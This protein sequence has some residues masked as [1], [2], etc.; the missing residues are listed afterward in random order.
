VSIRFPGARLQWRAEGEMMASVH[1]P[2]SGMK[3]FTGA[4]ALRAQEAYPGVDIVV[5]LQD[6]RLKSEFQLRAGV[7]PRLP[8]Y[9]LDGAAVRAGARGES[10]EVDAGDGWSWSEEGLKTWQEGPGGRR[11]ERSARFRIDGQCVSFAISGVDDTMPLTIDPELVFSSYL[12]GGMF[13][14]ITAVA[15]DSQGNLYLGGWTE[16]SDFLSL[17]GYQNTA[18]GRID[19]FVAKVNAAGQLVFSSYL[20]GAGEDRVQAIAVDGAGVITVAGLTSSTNFPTLSAARGTLAGGRDA[21]VTR[22]YPAGNQLVFSTYLGGSGHDAALGMAL[23]FSGN[24]VV[25]GET[26]S[27]DFPVQNA[28]ASSA[29]GGLDGFLARL[30]PAGALLSSSYFGGGADDRIRGV[31]VSGNGTLHLTG[32]TASGNFP[33]VAAPFPSLRGSMDAF[34]ARFNGAATAL[35]LSTYLGGGGGSSLSEEAGYGITI[36]MYGRAWIAGVT[37]SADFPGVSSGNQSTYGGGSADAFVSVFSASGGLEWSTFIG[38]SGLDAATSISAGSGFVGLAGYTTSNNLPVA[39][40][41]QATRAGEYDAFW[42]AF[43][44]VATAPLYISYLGGSGSDSALAAAAS[45]SSM[46]VGGS[47]LSSNFP[48]Q[49]PLQASNPGSYGGFVSRFRFGPGPLTVTPASGSGIAG[50]FTFS[51][52]HANG[53]NS[54]LNAAMLFNTSSSQANGCYIYYDRGS[55]QLSL[56]KDAGAMWLPIVPGTA[57]TADNGVCSISGAGVS[58][59]PTVNS[60]VIT[61][62]VTF[63][64]SFSGVRNIYA[65]A[66]DA[67]GLGAGWPQAGTWTVVAPAAPTVGAV[68]PASGSGLSRTFTFT[69]SDANGAADIATAS[70][71]FNNVYSTSNG[72][73]FVYSRT[74]NTISLFRDADSVFVPVTPGLNATAENANCAISGSGASATTLGSVLTL[75]VPVTFRSSLIGPR[76]V[77]GSVA[78][79]GGLMASWQQMGTWTPVVSAAPAVLSVY[80]STG[81]GSAQTFTVTFSDANGYTDIVSAAVLINTFVSTSGGCYLTFN[82]TTSQLSLLRDSDGAYLPLSPGANTTVENTVCSISGGGF[83]VSGAG[84]QLA[85]TIPVTFKPRVV[86]SRNIYASATDAASLTTGWQTVG[87]WT[88]VVASAPSVTGVTPASGSSSAQVFTFTFSDN[89]GFADISTVAFLFN[90]SATPGNGCSISYSVNSGTFTLL[91]DSDGVQLPISPGMAGAVE[92]T[93]CALAGAG[94]TVSGSG[95]QLVFSL[96]M[97]FYAAFSGTKTIYGSATDTLGLTSGYQAVG[98]W[99]PSGFATPTVTGVSPNAGSGPSQTFTV[100]L[101]DANGYEDISGATILFNS[102]INGENACFLFYSRAANTV[103]LFRDSDGTW[104]GLLPG[105]AGTVSNANCTLSGSALSITRSGTAISLVLPISFQ[106][107]FV[108]TKNIYVSVNDQTNRTSGWVT[109]GTWTPAVVVAAPTV[110]GISPNTGIGLAQTFTVQLADASGAADIASAAVRINTTNSASNGC[111]LSY[112]RAGGVFSLFQDAT[113]S[114][115]SLAP[116]SGSS[117]SNANCT[118]SGTGLGVSMSGNTLT[119]TLPLTFK[120]GFSGTKNI[121]ISATD[122]GGLSSN[123][124][125]AGSWTPESGSYPPTVV[126]L[127]PNAGTGSSQAFTLTLADPNGNADIGGANIIINGSINGTN[128]CFLSYSRAANTIYLFRDSD[129][130]WQPLSP[131]AAT[132]VSNANC[133]LAGTGFSITASGNSLILVLPFT[134]S[135]AF[136]GTKNFYV[137]VIDQGQLSS[138]WVTAGTWTTGTGAAPPTVSGVSPNSGYGAT[139]TFTLTLTDT[140]GNADIA[141]ANIIVNG[142]INGNNSCFLSYSRSANTIYL[143][144]DSDNSWQPLSPGQAATVSNDNCILA[145]AGFTVTGAGNNLVLTLPFTFK[146]GFTGVKNFYASVTDQSQ[147]SSGW[148]TAGT[149]SPAGAAS[150]PVVGGV[151]PNAGSGSSQAFTFS[152]SDANGGNDIAS[153]VILINTNIDGNNA[154]F[155]TYTRATGTLSLLRDSDNSW[156]SLTA[157]SSGSVAGRNCTISGSSLSG[158]VSGNTLTVTVPIVFSPGFAGTRNIYVS[159]TDSGGL[160]SGWVT[161]GTWN[162]SGATPAAPTVGAM[163]PAAGAGSAQTFSI[164]VSDANGN[165]DIAGLVLIVNSAINGQN[166]CFLSYSRAANAIYLF[167]DSDNSWQPLSLGASGSVSNSNCSISGAALSVTASGNTLK[168]QLPMTFQPTFAGAKNFYVSASDAGNLSSGWVVAGTWTVN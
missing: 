92:N 73:Y 113:S 32:S 49:S 112:D 45:G 66:N 47:T 79:A 35:S 61:L 38:G 76:G 159:V 17:S 156:L 2:G 108:G 20:G 106:A 72:C 160:S 105:S 24:V 154:C 125:T 7:W 139:Q 85:L 13:D 100:G 37:P 140:N 91:R 57:M 44:L 138:G 9:C 157:G 26:A 117:I 90:T 124:V 63:A 126:S 161:A 58:V 64:S 165:A 55:N 167:R 93:N 109:S 36:D 80:P 86:G 168:L 158:V 119:M 21:F 152:L 166:A 134:F 12:G 51:F 102:V 122:A 137:T 145:G 39:S 52:S 8:G 25:V 97:T 133:T 162:P 87:S 150:T 83:V 118:L 103:Y 75:T 107:G 31:A 128:A 59:S 130:S 98:T 53:A 136:L 115:L 42:A 16:S 88:P 1:F 149:W 5:R 33:S 60:L 104:Q 131:G 129:N 148:V 46:A 23:D 6:G 127:T 116:G 70:V 114:W 111:S 41:P 81:S 77:Y 147:L 54:I 48:L 78:D 142:S 146:P 163:T 18:S 56:Y 74:S 28:Y 15:T 89:N 71:F 155:F 67:A 121:Y 11:M 34:Y 132:T 40:A 151:S 22:L 62:P 120:A 27:S 84:T 3:S 123:W 135:S 4:G 29:G 65:N 68:T 69:F 110:T 141:G 10:V 14:A 95:T 101:S 143:F 144:R 99:N 96:P 82:G 43:P 50:T 30:S 164:P 153:A 94:L 19:G